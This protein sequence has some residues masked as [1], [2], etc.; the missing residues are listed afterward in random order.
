MLHNTTKL[1]IIQYSRILNEFIRTSTLLQKKEKKI[2]ELQNGLH[3]NFRLHGLVLEY[4]EKEWC[5]L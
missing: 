3:I 4:M 2:F 5:T 1:Y